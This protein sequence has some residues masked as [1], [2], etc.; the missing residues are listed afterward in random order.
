MDMTPNKAKLRDVF[1]MPKEQ[2][3]KM[4][5]DR[6]VS[7]PVPALSD[8]KRELIASIG[9]E[10]S[11]GV[12]I[13]YGWHTGVSEGEKV[14]NFEWE[15]EADLVEAGPKF[16]VMHGHVEE[17]VV[18]DIQFDEDNHVDYIRA[19]WYK[20]YEAEKYKQKNEITEKPVCHTL[21]GY[22]SGYLSTALQRTILVKETKCEAMGHDHCEI[23][24]MP[25]EKWGEEEKNEH[26]YYQSSSMI[27]ELDEVTAKLKEERDYLSQAHDVHKQ[28]IEGLLSKQELQKIIDLLYSTTGLPTFIEDDKSR[29]VAQSAEVDIDFDLKSLKTKTSTFC[30][31]SDDTGVLRTPILFE[32]EIK[33]YCSF[34]YTGFTRPND[35]EYMIIDQAS[36]TSSIIMLSENI[37]IQT[38]QNIRRG[39]LSDILDQRLDKEELY[40][41]AQY[42]EFEPD[43]DY[44]MLTFERSIDENDLSYELELNEKFLRCINLFLQERGINGFAS[45]KSG[46]IIT[47]IDHSSLRTVYPNQSEFIEK[48]LKHCNN[49]LNN[50]TF[51]V[52]V[53]SVS[54][55]IN[56]LPDLYS[57]T[58]TA[59]NVK[60]NEKHILYYNDLGVESILF[61]ISDSHILDR[62]V[63]NQIGLLLEDDKSQELISTLRDYIENGM[64]INAT[65]KAISMSISGLRYRLT[66]VSDLLGI[67][68]DD[69]KSLF[70]VYMALNVSKAKG[71]IDI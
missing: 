65:A 37:R 3:M 26:K 24:C 45:Q 57:E 17:V 61:Q 32:N 31:I 55:T 44:L 7:I 40:K 58:L 69:T 68:L 18:N 28:L 70:S 47:V 21:C 22:A 42:L 50:Y 39:F 59:L 67:E 56:E 15:D 36:L 23:V 16:H 27:Q 64:N 49:R 52:G 46:K 19:S 48:I 9:E 34:I 35:L 41:V 60:S 14:R 53:S 6:M 8:L 12:F 54:E 66:K 38:S 5:H 1:D 33:G 62:F 13:R 11:K 20:S 63:E 29:I 51:F 2:T 71:K 25:I 30:E 43:S 4:F 10:R